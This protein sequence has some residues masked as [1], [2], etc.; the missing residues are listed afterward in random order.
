MV[1]FGTT[2][3]V[4]RHEVQGTLMAWAVACTRQSYQSKMWCTRM[5]VVHRHAFAGMAANVVQQGIC[6]TVCACGGVAM[7]CATDG[8]GWVR[9]LAIAYSAHAC[10]CRLVVLCMSASTCACAVR[11]TVP[12]RCAPKRCVIASLMP[13]PAQQRAICAVVPLSLALCWGCQAHNVGVDFL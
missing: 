7:V 3:Y 8:G 12:I 10:T 2:S 6:F 13:D 4:C 5:C 11:L 1:W 9:L